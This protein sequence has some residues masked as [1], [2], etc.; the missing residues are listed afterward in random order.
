[1]ARAVE[2]RPA[3]N[4]AVTITRFPDLEDDRVAVARQPL[5]T[6]D[7]RLFGWELLFRSTSGASSATRDDARATTHV[8]S[9][10]FTE[11]GIRELVGDM[12]CFLN[13]TREFLVGELPLPFDPDRVVLEVLETVTVDDDLVLGLRAL[14][15]RGYAIALDDFVLHG[16]HEDLLDLATYVK[17]DFVATPHADLRAAGPRLRSR[18]LLLV[19]EKLETDADVALAT[20]MG[21]FLLQGY[22]FGRPDTLSKAAL[23]GGGARRLEL[24]AALGADDVRMTEVVEM[25][26]ADPVLTVR[27]LRAANSAAAGLRRAVSSVQEAVVALGLLKVRQ[28]L[29]LIV[30]DDVNA[31]GPEVLSR[32]LVRARMC[33]AV[34]SSLGASG[35]SGFMTGLLHGVAEASDVTL[36]EL[37]T[38]LP[39]AP[40]VVAALTHGHGALGTALH[41]VLAFEPDAPPDSPPD[42]PPD[43]PPDSQVLTPQPGRGQEPRSVELP[44]LFLDAVAWSNA[45][46]TLPLAGARA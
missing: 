2:R 22:R 39:L 44:P 14:R 19:A 46:L 20:E 7:G 25:V 28:W 3:D 4:P 13:L 23:T 42:A 29:S 9:S 36:A 5:Y 17:L 8:I 34:A 32:L 41:T 31:H 38:Q 1:M 37:V 43:S 11:F 10:A 45:M 18:G 6:A 12:H 21:C 40:P 35:D 30:L 33:Q 24:L 27:L 26:S 16:P 15:E